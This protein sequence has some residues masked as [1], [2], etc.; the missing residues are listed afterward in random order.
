MKGKIS[1][2]RHLGT[3]AR[4]YSFMQNPTGCGTDYSVRFLTQIHEKVSHVQNSACSCVHFP[5]EST[6]CLFVFFIKTDS[7]QRE[8]SLTINLT[9]RRPPSG[10]RTVLVPGKGDAS[11]QGAGLFSRCC[12]A[13]KEGLRTENKGL[14]G[15]RK[16]GKAGFGL[17]GATINSGAGNYRTVIQTW[18]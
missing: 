5:G 8:R 13:K 6:C 17:R 16:P 3:D 7:Q 4:P 2:Y 15:P 1:N 18:S 12:H 14:V 9:E 11:E 10:S